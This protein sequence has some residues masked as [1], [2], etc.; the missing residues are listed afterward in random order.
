[1]ESF[2]LTESE[3]QLMR[4][5]RS[6][7]PFQRIEIMADGEA[8]PGVYVVTETSKRMVFPNK[9]VFIQ[10]KSKHLQSSD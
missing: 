9:Q 10:I 8:R 3:Q 7:K 6:L 4:I 1:M 2:D 5:I